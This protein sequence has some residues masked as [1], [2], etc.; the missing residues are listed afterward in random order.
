VLEPRIPV[1]G[2]GVI[3]VVADPTGAV[4]GLFEPAMA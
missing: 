1:P 4:I 2:V 3:A